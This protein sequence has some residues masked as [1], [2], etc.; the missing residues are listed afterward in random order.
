MKIHD[1]LLKPISEV[2]YLRAENVERYRVMIRYFY[3]EYEKIHYW[4]Y[5]EEL[6]E[7]MIQT[8]LFSDYTLELCQADLDALTNWKNLTAMQDSSRVTSPKDFINRKYRYQLSDYTIEI[9][10]MTI[11]LETLEIEGASLEPTLLERIHTM[12]LKIPS[13]L[14]KTDQEVSAWWNDLNNDFIR[15]NRNYQD[16]IRTLNNAKAEEMMKT[17]QF[18]VFKEKIIQYL[19]SFVKGLQEEALG[20]EEFIKEIDD[21]AIETLIQKVI[22]YEL[23]IP[24]ID[25]VLNKDDLY[26]NCNGRWHSLYSWFVGGEQE[27]EV[28]RMSDITLEIIRKITRYAQQ[29]GE[30]HNQG[31]N[32]KEEYRH[33]ASLFGQC[34]NIQEAHKMSAM[35]FGAETCFHF[36]N[37]SDRDTD[38]IDSGIYEEAPTFYGLE[39]RSK[40]VRIKSNRKPAP[41]YSLEKMMQEQEIKA[42]QEKDQALLNSYIKDGRIDFAS[43][44]YLDAYSRKKLL[45]WLSKGLSASN[46]RSKTEWG[47]AYIVDDSNKNLCKINC[48]D[49]TFYMPSFCIYFEKEEHA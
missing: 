32:R 46:H 25:R 42:K 45:N 49:G 16:Y 5:K 43:I 17:E 22:A 26:E 30:L 12:I 47:S 24:R 33:I 20:L 31:A 28:N 48:E 35:V 13:M 23:S 29:I 6:Y 41:D 1:K 11:R 38:S 2:S 4:L 10:R 8:G 18:L 37:L 19:R 3:E 39:P 27:S 44:T 14:E 7:M 21:A 36:K 15:L 9:E 34:A 40:I